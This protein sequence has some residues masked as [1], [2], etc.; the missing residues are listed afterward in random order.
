[1]PP[2]RSCQRPNIPSRNH[3]AH[4]LRSDRHGSESHRGRYDRCRQRVLQKVLGSIDLWCYS[5]Q[6]GDF[7]WKERHCEVRK[8]TYGTLKCMDY[9]KHQG[10][11]RSITCSNRCWSHESFRHQRRKRCICELHHQED[12][13]HS[14]YRCR[15]SCCRQIHDRPVCLA[16]EMGRRQSCW[17]RRRLHPRCHERSLRRCCSFLSAIRLL[18]AKDTF[19]LQCPRTRIYFVNE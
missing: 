7:I 11:Q 19:C 8:R 16:Y 2:C 13:R 15:K 3:Y 14:D 9:S 5:D 6:L 4:W 1:M 18:C 10:H 17:V 12:C